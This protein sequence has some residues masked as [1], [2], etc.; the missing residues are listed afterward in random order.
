MR[1]PLRF[2]RNHRQSRLPRSGGLLQKAKLNEGGNTVVETDLFD[3]L[4][5]LHAQDRHAGEVHLA[6]RRGG[7]S[8]NQEV[9]ERGARVR[10]AAFPAADDVVVLG[11]PV[12][13]AT[14]VEVPRWLGAVCA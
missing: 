4:T 9:A 10:A 5:V 7:E 8:A 6:S 2:R 14:G 3:D 12:R 13:G 11:A 1:G